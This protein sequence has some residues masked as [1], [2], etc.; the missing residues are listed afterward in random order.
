[1][2][3][4]K[5]FWNNF[6]TISGVV[7]IFLVGEFLNS[8][9]LK[10]SPIEL[11]NNIFCLKKE[12][13]VAVKRE[14]KNRSAQTTSLPAICTILFITPSLTNN[15]VTG[16]YYTHTRFS[17]IF[18]EKGREKVTFWEKKNDPF[19]FLEKHFLAQMNTVDL[20][21][22]TTPR[23]I[24]V[25]WWPTRRRRRSYTPT[26]HSW[27]NGQTTTRWLQWIFPHNQSTE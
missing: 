16:S 5:Y 8:H 27:V 17:L 13:V 18:E 6:K 26:N 9:F 11:E 3:I 1:M 24:L 10:F 15:K 7:S 23:F 22:P 14:N 4:K 2:E 20:P 12:G 19:V 21:S 25:M